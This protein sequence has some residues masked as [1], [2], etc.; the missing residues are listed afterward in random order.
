[1]NLAHLFHCLYFNADPDRDSDESF[2][3]FSVFLNNGGVKVTCMTQG[4]AVLNCTGAVSKKY[5]SIENEIWALRLS[6]LN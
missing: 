4:A 6:V 2:E 5:E 3:T 1:M